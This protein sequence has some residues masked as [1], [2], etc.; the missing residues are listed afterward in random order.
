MNPFRRQLIEEAWA[1]MEEQISPIQQDVDGLFY[2]RLDWDQTIRPDPKEDA[3]I[4]R[5]GHTYQRYA[6]VARHLA[7]IVDVP[8]EADVGL[9]MLYLQAQIDQ[10]K[11]KEYVLTIS[12]WIDRA[13]EVL[14][15]VAVVES[16]MARDA[17]GRLALTTMTGVTRPDGAV[18][19]SE[20][21]M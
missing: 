13:P 2:T 16:E 11:G 1:W 3:Q 6:T 8:D 9:Y 15:R 20:R 12:A 21:R 18:E 5:V 7:E 14:P 10:R 19:A 17:L 4:F